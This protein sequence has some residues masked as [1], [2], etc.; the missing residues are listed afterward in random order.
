M[1]AHFVI[2]ATDNMY[3]SCYGP[4]IIVGFA[5]ANIASAKDLL[6]FSWNE[7]FLEL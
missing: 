7:K 5:V 3:V 6:N 2:I 4:E 1:A